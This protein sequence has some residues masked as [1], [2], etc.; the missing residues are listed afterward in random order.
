MD[1]AEKSIN[2]VNSTPDSNLY[3]YKLGIEKITEDLVKFGLT[4]SQ[5]K[6]FIY[7]GKYGSKTSPEVCK[8]L[9]LPRTETYHILNALTN[10]GIVETEF[11]HP[12]KYSAINMEKA[13]QIMVKTE[14]VKLD[15]LAE[16]EKEITQLWNKI[17]SFFTPSS[18][19]ECDKF[20]MLQGSPR[21]HSK[22][23]NMISTANNSCKLLCGAKD[24]SRFYYSNLLENLNSSKL[25]SRLIISSDAI[26]PEFLGNLPSSKIKS[27]PHIMA[28]NQCFLIKDDSELI[29][30]LRNANF[31]AKEIF[32]FWTDSKSLIESIKLLFDYSWKNSKPIKQTKLVIQN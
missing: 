19:T 13:I 6:V 12:T 23:K 10:R 15:M 7:L 26:T 30:F 27:L 11:S 25:D 14:Q 20:Q 5:A 4:K 17:P 8:D 32:A 16:K 1:G 18:Q 2:V 29:I 31:P 22:M 28:R 21:I 24:L 9:K 3:V